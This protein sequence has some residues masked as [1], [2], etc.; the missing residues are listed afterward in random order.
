[1]FSAYSFVTFFLLTI[2]VVTK[3]SSGQ[4]YIY[5]YIVFCSLWPCSP[6]WNRE[7]CLICLEWWKLFCTFALLKPLH[8]RV[9]EEWYSPVVSYLIGS[10]FCADLGLAD[11]LCTS[12]QWLHSAV[13]KGLPSLPL[14][15]YFAVRMA[16]SLLLLP[17]SVLK[18]SI[19]SFSFPSFFHLKH[20]IT[21]LLQSV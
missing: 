3:S 18:V 10:Q 19:R 2:W 8:K 4:I 13:C 20:S 1:M 5:I 11:G 7:A 16:P 6:A 14:H 17:C 21:N 15:S 12:L 9:S